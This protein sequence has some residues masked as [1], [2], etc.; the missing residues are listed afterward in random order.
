MDAG[1]NVY[2]IHSTNL[3]S[4]ADGRSGRVLVARNVTDRVAQDER[5]IHQERLAVLGEV[6][7]IV[8]LFVTLTR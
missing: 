4:A 1:S 7:T 3:S 2:E 8:L 6:A 5:E